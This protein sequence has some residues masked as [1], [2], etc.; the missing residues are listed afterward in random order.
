MVEVGAGSKALWGRQE[1]K[2]GLGEGRA[3]P[4]QAQWPSFQSS[5]QVTHSLPAHRFTGSGTVAKSFS[6]EPRV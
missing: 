6:N 2:W 4:S 5:T 1:R 3:L